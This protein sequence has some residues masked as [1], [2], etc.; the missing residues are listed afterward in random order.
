[1]N[2]AN[3]PENRAVF[4]PQ[5]VSAKPWNGFHRSPLA[6]FVFN[7]SLP[8]TPF[9]L[10]L[11]F[12]RPVVAAL[13][14]VACSQ[15][16]S[17]Q[18]SNPVAAPSAETGWFAFTPA[19]DLTERES[20]FDLR[21]LN[22][23]LAGAD[24][25]V[26]QRDGQF[27]LAGSDRPVRFWGV[28]GPSHDAETPEQLARE[29]KLLARYGVNLVRVHGS[30]FDE[31]GTLEPDRVRR[32]IA[33]AAA[34]KR[35][36]IYVL[37][38]IYFP[39]WLKPNADHPWLRGYNGEQHP[40]AALMFNEDFQRHYQDWWRT[41][42]LTPGADGA[43]L[44]DDPAVLALEIQNEDSF[45]FWTFEEKNL[46][47]PQRELIERRFAAWLI[48]KYGSLDAA[49]T[50]WGGP[51]L[52][53]DRP[54]E[55]RI[56]FRKLH[57]IFTERTA[58]DRDTVGFLLE[59]QRDFYEKQSAFLRDLGYRGLITCSN[60]TTASAEILG[61]LEKYSYTVGQFVDRHGYFGSRARGEG[62][63][64]SIRDGHTYRDR[65]ALRFEPDDGQPG[66][67]FVHPVMDP[68]Y[69]RLPSMISETT[70]TRPNRYRSE[71]PLYYAAYGAL[72]DSDA[73]VHFSFDGSTWS[74]KPNYWMQPWTL[75]SPAMIGQFP[76]AALLYR[77][78]LVSTGD[79]LADVQLGLDDLLAL[80]GTPLPQDAALD[81]L[82]LA[83]ALQNSANEST[84][85]VIDP[86]I[87]YAGRTRV[88]FASGATRAD[89]GNLRRFIDREARRVTSTTREL[90]LDYRH[91]FLR[92]DAP[93]AQGL[94][95][96]LAAAGPVEL[97]D[98]HVESPLE[99][100]HIVLV[101]LDG[102]PLAESRRMLLQTMSEERAT[103]FATENAGEGL[104]RIVSIGTDPW[105]VRA[106]SGRL[107][108]KSTDRLPRVTALDLA[109][110]P[111]REVPLEHAT[112]TLEPSTVYYLLER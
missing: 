5:H 72:Q 48:S 101:A 99:L 74:V 84:P 93:S 44:I 33:I 94:S 35:E 60:W 79:I 6:T 86:L 78:R 52:P 63:E 2:L 51:A 18:S 47:P 24:G 67:L 32:A 80:K 53:G 71:A 56:A 49:L 82:R 64:W 14:A 1:M 23:P 22:E 9:M 59:A 16:G 62:A 8:R 19:E 50:A 13:L 41:L 3:L 37:Y 17:A 66:Q 28:N 29:A 81:E 15:L 36:G 89:V 108:F 103:G 91:G 69:A 102:R 96:S 98:I 76:A 104:R 83:D 11:P 7:A 109:G 21:H 34:M 57:P 100:G 61:P 4:S 75:M 112:L 97:R 31:N 42:L 92:I 46:P 30:L 58:R 87:H 38:S 43:R 25:Y 39:L 85:A 95:G 26:S 105:Q 54:A 27:F 73:I 90:L 88:D 65:S 12:R 10:R 40:F 107:T 45:F 77:E 20:V 68:E 55:G 106:L 70:W 111:N 110:R